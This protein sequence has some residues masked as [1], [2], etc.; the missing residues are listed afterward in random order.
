MLA[1]LHTHSFYSFDGKLNASPDNI[2][3]AAIAAGLTHVAVTDH[4]DIDCE[5]AGLYRPLDRAAAFDALAAAKEKYKDRI[6]LL[7]GI[8][9][10]QAHHCPEAAR[11]L[12]AERP[13]DIVLGSLHNLANER[14]FA[15]FDF[16]NTDE[17]EANALFARVI[18]EEMLL[19]DFEGIHA[20]THLTYMDRY[21][22]RA[23]KALAVAPHR[24]AL[25]RLF[26]KIVQKGLVLELNTSC[27]GEELGMP[28]P[29]ILSLYRSVGG[30][31][32]CLGSDAHMP[33]RIAQHFE[34]GFRLLLDCGFTDLTLP[35][36]EKTLTY[37]IPRRNPNV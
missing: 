6:T 24:D 18:A 15:F 36:R 35:T 9:L 17:D 25:L 27:L 29:E 13:Y 31:R 2:A 12:L 4:C 8:E 3:R 10:G 7:I 21:L 30:T 20:I 14:D 34:K 22:H 11:A 19:C 26:E 5:L 33:D 32:V 28:T 16:T 23:G 37:P 1:D